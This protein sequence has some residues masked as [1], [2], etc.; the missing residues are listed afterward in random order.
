MLDSPSFHRN[1]DPLESVLKKIL[2]DETGHFLEVGSGSGQHI[3]RFATCFPN[4]QF[5]PSEIDPEKFESIEAWVAQANVRNVLPPLKLD[6]VKHPW[7]LDASVRFDV[8]FVSNVI[9]ISPWRV[10]E[11]IFEGATQHATD[12]AK[13]LFYGPFKLNGTHTAAS[14][15]QFEVWLKEQSPDFGVR[16]IKEVSRVAE[17]NGF[18][19]ANQH[20]MPANN[21]L[22]EFRRKP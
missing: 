10:T 6:V 5:Q 19:L 1:I 22:M 12:L 7:L 20:T 21:F 4:F 13:I 16:D 3:A 18:A 11:A 8:I 15:E 2:A 17:E 9:H 14:N